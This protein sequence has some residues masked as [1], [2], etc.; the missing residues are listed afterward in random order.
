MK[1]GKNSCSR[2]LKQKR[3]EKEKK[4]EMEMGK[5]S[6]QTRKKTKATEN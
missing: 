6:N 3:E 1:V 4:R 5:T 2:N